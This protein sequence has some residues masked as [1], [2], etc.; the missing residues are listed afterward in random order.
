MG[1]SG[2]LHTPAGRGAHGGRS[3]RYS[4]LKYVMAGVLLGLVMGMQVRATD[5]CW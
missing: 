4:Y 5:I 1:P 2:P 3:G